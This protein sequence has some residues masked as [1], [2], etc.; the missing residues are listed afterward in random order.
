MNRPAVIH[1]G[2][3]QRSIVTSSSHGFGVVGELLKEAVL[4]QS[5]LPH[6][7]SDGFSIRMTLWAV[8]GERMER[9]ITHSDCTVFSQ[10]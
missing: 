4:I 3:S 6:T 9:A 2:V 8:D 10:D 1:K 5:I 7:R